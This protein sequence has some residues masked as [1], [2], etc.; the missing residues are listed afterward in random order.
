MTRGLLTNEQIRHRQLVRLRRLLGEVAESNSF[1]APRIRS[2]GLEK[3]LNSLDEF[4]S[5]MPFTLKS[6]LARDQEEHPLYGTNLTYP[7][8]EYTR[9][10]QTS[11]TTG[12][13]LRWL[14]TNDSWAWMVTGW[15]EVLR[16]AEVSSADRVLVAFS[17]GPFIGLWLAFEAAEGLGC[18]A[19][20]GGGLNSEAR[21]KVLLANEVTV[22]CCT[23]TYA[24]RLGESALELGIDLAQSKVRAIVV[25]G[26]PGA[27]VPATR[28]MIKQ[29]WPG[30][31][32][33]DH[34]GMTEA[35]PV[36]FQ[37]TKNSEVVHVLESFHICEVVHPE[38]GDPLP[39]DAE[40][41]GELVVTNLGRTGSPILRYRTGDLV[42]P[43]RGPCACGR[44]LLSLEGG[45]LSRADDMVVIRGV[46]LY[47]TAVDQIVRGFEGIAEYRVEIR[48]ERGMDELELQIEPNDGRDPTSLCQQIEKSFRDA[49]SLR[50]PVVAVAPGTLPRFE[51]K[52]RRWVRK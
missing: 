46:N 28:A 27:S 42:R 31:E 15:E 39:P 1:Y 43:R 25:G 8:T 21:L 3:S 26:E 41:L 30:A 51:L 29:R 48:T 37:C 18:L 5:K 32:L 34:Y 16:G 49:Y 50:V 10:H 24:L 13:P 40:I 33:F 23:P 14:D 20:P 35:G 4:T 17:F 52:S 12:K 11:S 9:L 2:A 6:E 47:P 19:I 38:T 44:D 45:I 7:L 36:T 22:L